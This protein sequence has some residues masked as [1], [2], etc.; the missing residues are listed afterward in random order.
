ML[1]FLIGEAHL[2]FAADKF[3]HPQ[4]VIGFH[5]DG[6]VYDFPVDGVLRIRQRLIE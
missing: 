1:L 2:V 6:N 3:R 4:V 5:G